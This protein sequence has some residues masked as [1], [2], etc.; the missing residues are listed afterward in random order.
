[1]AS[2]DLAA[3]MPRWSVVKRIAFRFLFVYALAMFLSPFNQVSAI[4]WHHLG[5]LVA[6]R[7]WWLGVVR[8][9]SQQVFGATITALPLGSGDTTFNYVEVFCWITIAAALTLVWSIV[10]WRRAS[11]PRLFAGMRVAV[12]LYLA[13]V[14]IDYGMSKVL[15]SQFPPLQPH[16]LVESVGEMS[17]MGL[18]WTFMSASP[19]YT[20]FGG[21]A[22]VLGGLLL[23]SRRTTLLGALV[24]A[25]VMSQVVVINLCYD[26][27]VK[28]FSSHL[29]AM[30]IFLVAPDLKRLWDLFVLGRPVAP[31]AARPIFPQRWLRWSIASVIAGS[32]A[33][34]TITSLMASYHE[35]EASGIFAPPPPLAGIWD[36]VEFQRDGKIVPPLTTEAT[37]WKQVLV[38]DPNFVGVTA[39]AIIP[40]T[41]PPDWRIMQMDEQARRIDLVSPEQSQKP[42][43][44]L[45]FAQP[46]KDT[47][48]VSGTVDGQTVRVELRQTPEHAL[49]TN[50]GFHWINETPF[51]R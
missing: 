47:L 37:R 14:M 31:A 51:N 46:A 19:W 29:L 6:G 32:F 12:R 2:A 27:P 7:D 10:D 38:E 20:M 9:V 21:A 13:F 33:Y 1:M 17:P 25:G 5:L 28:L 24:T 4:F 16:R 11:Y 34:L 23:L 44:T 18:M 49:L 48:V 41:G 15:P 35:V 50:R 8:F 42:T 43:G 22:E 45:K 30:S 39:M 3:E 26:V 36:V 40:M